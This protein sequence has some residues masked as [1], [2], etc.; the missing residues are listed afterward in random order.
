VEHLKEIGLIL[1]PNC[2]YALASK[3][4]STQKMEYE[5]WRMKK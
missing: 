3:P 1:I 2:V 5:I 4:M